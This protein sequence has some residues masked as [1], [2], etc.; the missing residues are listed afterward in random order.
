MQYSAKTYHSNREVIVNN[1]VGNRVTL[2]LLIIRD[3]IDVPAIEHHVCTVLNVFE[4]LQ[5][6][7]TLIAC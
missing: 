6:A 5:Q 4:D 2:L 7:T 3:N 1:A